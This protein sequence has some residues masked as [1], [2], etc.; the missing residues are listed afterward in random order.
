VTYSGGRPPARKTLSGSIVQGIT[1]YLNRVQGPSGAFQ[2]FAN[3]L[4]RVQGRPI[5]RSVQADQ[6]FLPGTRNFPSGYKESELAAGQ[7][8]ENFRRGAGFVGQTPIVLGTR[9]GVTPDLT[10]SDTYKQY[11]QTPS[12]QFERYF[13]TPEFDYVFGGQT[14]KGPKTAAEMETLGT[15]RQAPTSAPLADY[16][17]SQSAMGRVNQEEIQKMYADR[18][19][20]QKWAAA[21]PMLAQREY[22][23]RQGGRPLAL[24]QKTVM[25]DLGSRAQ[26]ERGYTMEAFGLPANSF[27]VPANGVPAPWNQQGAMVDENRGVANLQP[28]QAKFTTGEGMPAFPTTGQKAEDFLR[29]VKLSNLF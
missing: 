8:A 15:Q 29:N 27:S 14:G 13:N 20:L 7:R 11:A 10:Q 26:D 4:N 17:R 19:D 1:D 5:G 23:K 24:D 2:D 3:Y 9:D 6:M 12:G 28:E 21:N 16:Y 22:V 18:P 25:G